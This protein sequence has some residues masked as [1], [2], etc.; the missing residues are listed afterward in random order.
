M[1][2]IIRLAI[3]LITL[4]LLDKSILAQDKE[5]IE[6]IIKHAIFDSVQEKEMI[7]LYE[8]PKPS[9]EILINYITSNKEV[10]AGCID[11]L[12]SNFFP[13][14]ITYEGVIAARIIE[15]LM[16]KNASYSSSCGI[17]MN[18]F[19]RGIIIKNKDVYSRLSKSDIEHLYRIYNSW[20][21]TSNHFDIRVLR[22]KIKPF[23]SILKGSIYK[24]L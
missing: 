3:V 5:S 18:G 8:N 17:N 13:G 12:S 1:I 2:K 24:W 22:N 9:I 16:E 23:H 21:Q 6:A 11:S 15:W 4:L 19:R 20:W 10:F 7:S 14:H